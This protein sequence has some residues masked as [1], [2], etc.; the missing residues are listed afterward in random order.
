[1]VGY[2]NS[3]LQISEKNILNSPS[4]LRGADIEAANHGY[5]SPSPLQATF[6]SPL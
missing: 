3:L 1:M 6:S 2:K 5:S 4:T